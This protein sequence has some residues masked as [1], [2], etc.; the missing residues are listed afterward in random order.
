MAFQAERAHI[1]QVALA[2]PLDDGHDMIGVPERLASAPSPLSRGSNTRAAAQPLQ[3]PKLRNAID[4]A[5]GAYSTVALE[6]AFAQMSR[7][8]A[9]S[10][11][12]DAPLRA[13][14]ASPR[15]NF[16]VAPS[17]QAAAAFALGKRNAVGAPAR[18]RAL[19]ARI[20]L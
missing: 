9:Q 6:K 5:R 4:A 10:P 11:L 1:R 14:R 17:A 16:Q 8:A 15:R 20:F 7:I 3:S 2:T 18:H 12:L 19:S 13:E